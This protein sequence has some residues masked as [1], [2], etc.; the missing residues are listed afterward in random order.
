MK[1]QKMESPAPFCS[2]F[3]SYF[4][5]AR[6]CK[7]WVI[8]A[9]TTIATHEAHTETTIAVNQLW[10]C[11][12]CAFLMLY[13]RLKWK[14]MWWCNHFFR[15]RNL[16][17][18]GLTNM[19]ISPGPSLCNS[20]DLSFI[21]KWNTEISNDDYCNCCSICLPPPPLSPTLRPPPIL[22]NLPSAEFLWVFSCN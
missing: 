17:S 21:V 6:D 20:T 7:L 19:S 11:L 14:K 13:D 12:G 4:H 22:N 5:S 1:I 3:F 16:F 10:S 8:P 18:R 15:K 2:F 9:S